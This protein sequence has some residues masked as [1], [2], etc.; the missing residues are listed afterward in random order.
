ML[1]GH[2]GAA[3]LTAKYSKG[4]EQDSVKIAVLKKDGTVTAQLQVAPLDEE[5]LSQLM[6]TRPKKGGHKQDC[7]DSSCKEPS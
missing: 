5:R 7:A 6:V 1:P 3:A 4:A 2:L